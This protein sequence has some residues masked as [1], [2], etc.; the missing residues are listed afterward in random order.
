MWAVFKVFWSAD[1]E[2][3]SR[4][5]LS[6]TKFYQFCNY[7]LNKQNHK[8]SK[9]SKHQIYKLVYSTYLSAASF[10]STDILNFGKEST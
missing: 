4:I 6:S 10:R 9:I 5:F 3:E 7:W 8:F 2:S 1:F